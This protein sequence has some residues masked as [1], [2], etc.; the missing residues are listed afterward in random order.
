[1]PPPSATLLPYPTLFRSKSGLLAKPSYPFRNF[2]PSLEVV[3]WI[4]GP[5]RD[6]EAPRNSLL[7]PEGQEGIPRQIPAI[8]RTRLLFP[9]TLR[10]E[11]HTSELQSL[12]H[13]VC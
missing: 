10:S 1:P 7:F 8:I 9:R 5:Q 2:R 11:E 12:R 4:P 13:L 6:P 3:A